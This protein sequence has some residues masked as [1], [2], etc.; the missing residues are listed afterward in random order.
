MKIVNYTELRENL[1]GWLDKVVDDVEE[2]VITRKGRKD[3]VMVSLEEYNAL[4][5]THYLLSGKNKER[6]L[7][8][9]KKA[10]AGDYQSKDLIEE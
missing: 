10:K 7:M 5:E 8:S 2:V 3:I 1:K 9:A 4:K 6:L